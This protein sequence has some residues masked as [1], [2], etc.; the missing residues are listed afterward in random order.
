MYQFIPTQ[1]KNFTSSFA[2]MIEGGGELVQKGEIEKA[3]KILKIFLNFSTLYQF[4]A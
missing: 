3:E 2:Q 1:F 4:I